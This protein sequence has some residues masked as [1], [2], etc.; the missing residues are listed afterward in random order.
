[1]L[2]FIIFDILSSTYLESDMV[3]IN[4]CN[5]YC[6]NSESEHSEHMTTE[7]KPA[8]KPITTSNSNPELKSSN[9]GYIP[10]NTQND[11]VK[12]GPTAWKYPIP[13]NS[14]I[15]SSQET[16]ATSGVLPS[17]MI[18]NDYNILP[19]AENN[20]GSFEMGYSMLPP[21]MW[22]PT[23]PNPPVCVTEKSCP[24]CP[25]AT[26]GYG[27]DLLE[28]NRS[29]RIMPPDTINVKYVEDKLNSGR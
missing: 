6:S 17:D 15:V 27:V 20:T 29:R 9:I 19:M 8:L 4:Q 11:P 1:M 5:S 10:S 28:W 2:A 3:S 7:I 14:Q 24:I 13:E 16:R 26:D 21:S 18:Y 22:Y 25:V 23:P 12:I